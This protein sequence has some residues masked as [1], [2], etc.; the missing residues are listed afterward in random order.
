E[1]GGPPTRDF[2]TDQHAL[3]EYRLKR[4]DAFFKIGIL[5]RGKT[6]HVWQ[7]KF[8]GD[9]I[10]SFSLLSGDRA[11]MGG[12]FGLYLV[13]LKTGRTVREFIGHAGMVWSVSPAPNGRYFMTGCTDQVL[14]IWHPER[15]EPILSFFFAGR[16]WIAW[17]PEGY[18]AASANGERLMGW[19][20]VNGPEKLATFHP[21]AQFRAS[22]YNPAALKLLLRQAG[23]HID[24]ALALA[25]K[26][27]KPV[28]ALNVGQ[29][30]PPEVVIKS[31]GPDTQAEGKV[32][33]KATATS[34]GDNPVTSMRLLVDGRPY[35]G[36]KGVVRFP[37]PKVGTVEASWPA[38]ELP[39]G[40][41]IFAV[42]AESKVSKG[43]SRPVEVLRAAT[44]EQELPNLYILACGV[45]EYPGPNRL[46]YAASDA[47]L[48]TNKFKEKAAGVFGKV[49]VSL[50]LD[51]QGTKKNIEDGLV[52]LEGKMT[53][54][55]V[56]IFF[57]SGHGGKDEKG[58]FYLITVD[59]TPDLERT[60]VSGEY[61]KEKL[62]NMSGRM[63][64]MLD[65][66]HSGAVASEGR[67]P[68]QA[69]DLV[70]DLVTDDYGIVCMC[71]SLGSEYSLESPETEAG[72]F[73][74]SVVEGMDGAADIDHDRIIYIHELDYYS[75]WRVRELSSG[76]QNPVTGRP[77]G[78][79]S[80]PLG[81]P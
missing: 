51:G 3:G 16:D 32:E 23:G 65:C 74:K 63:V 11:V 54:K 67:R 43:L 38:V 37:A 21:A 62:A 59:V 18:Y 12:S 2:I 48:I 9:R 69:D 58:N 31:P 13:D 25:G 49:E 75:T 6:L 55:D 35:R 34:K 24:R 22:L 61:V 50:N 28:L 1:F 30:L 20:I 15:T 14:S 78:V 73:T 33:V 80:F 19:L 52:W 44:G 81:R 68:G 45:S 77:A 8:E 79:H 71:S 17:T 4:V 10:Y 47:K 56:G 36:S 76:Q 29:V 39:P 57:F 66:C 26:P 46:R 53:P 70:R 5:H 27:D 72:F 40:K 64:C 60:C 41:H 7:S 42:Q